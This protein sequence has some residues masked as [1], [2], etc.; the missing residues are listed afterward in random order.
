[1]QPDRS[2]DTLTDHFARV[3]SIMPHILLATLPIRPISPG[4]PITAVRIGPPDDLARRQAEIRAEW[5]R[6]GILKQLLRR[7][8]NHATYWKTH[9]Q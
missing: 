3:F 2:R 1:M 4:S 8:N 5:E 7:E 9:S 6:W